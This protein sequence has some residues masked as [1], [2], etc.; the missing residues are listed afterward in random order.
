M[1][2][3]IASMYILIYDS[4]YSESGIYDTLTLY[5]NAIMDSLSSDGLLHSAYVGIRAIAFGILTVYFIISFGTKMQGRETSSSIVFKTLLEY[6]IGFALAFESFD[7]VVNFFKLGDAL[8]AQITEAA[9]DVVSLESYEGTLRKS[10]EAIG[11]TTQVG[12]IFKALVPYLICFIVNCFIIYIIVTRVLRVCVNAVLSPIA[13]C[14]FFDGSRHSDGVRFIKKTLAMC[15]Q[16]SAIMVIC[17]AASSLSMY[18]A[19]DG[20]RVAFFK[21][22][23]TA[24]ND[25]VKAKNDMVESQ[26]TNVSELKTTV[27]Q[28]RINIGQIAFNDPEI[29][30]NNNTYIQAADKLSTSDTAKVTDDKEDEY[31][32]YEEQLKIKIFQRDLDGHYI[33]N[34]DGYAKLRDEYSIF[35]EEKMLTFMNMLLNGNNWIMVGFISI[36]KVGLIRKS[37]SLCNVIVGL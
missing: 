15:L 37:N 28:A 20:S 31:K 29:H 25:V 26:A 17:A 30:N 6:F 19:T 12:Y 10:I 4:L 2:K 32:K 8:A 3:F 1:E 14:N 36:V 34:D 22:A 16:C 33:Y 23:I 27:M 11:F 24:K 13:V 5:S 35:N 7:I 18:M 21:G 9:A